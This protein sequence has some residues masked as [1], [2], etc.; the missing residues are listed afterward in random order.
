[1]IWVLSNSLKYASTTAEYLLGCAVGCCRGSSDNTGALLYAYKDTFNNVSYDDDDVVMVDTLTAACPVS[2][3]FVWLMT[4]T[5]AG[6][7]HCQGLC[8]HL[9]ASLAQCE[10]VGEISH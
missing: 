2:C 4:R 6:V 1:M 8:D 10:P 5:A 3:V 7:C 9:L